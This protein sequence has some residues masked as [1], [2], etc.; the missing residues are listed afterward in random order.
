MIVT[1]KSHEEKEFTDK[2]LQLQ[3]LQ[4]QGYKVSV[5]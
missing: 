1:E 2:L 4:G 3:I 5:L